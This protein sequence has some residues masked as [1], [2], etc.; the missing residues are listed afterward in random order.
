M[1]FGLFDGKRLIQQWRRPSDS[2]RKVPHNFRCDGVVVASVVPAL[3]QALRVEIKK[4]FG[5]RPHFVSGRNIKGI[6]VK[7]SKAEVGADRVVDALAAYRLYGGPCIIVDFGTAT[8][9]DVISA[10]GEYLGGAIAPGIMLGRDALYERTAKLPLVEIKVPRSVIG[11][12]TVTAIQSGLVFGYVAM[13]E[14]MI[15]RIKS[16][17]KNQ[18]SKMKVIATGGLAML[19]CKYAKGVDSVDPFLTLK[20]LQMIGEEI[21]GRRTK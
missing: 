10:A 20:G 13:V 6:R 2:F 15:Q 7:V 17:I 21:Y 11:T 5:I 14:G 9:F 16:K 18:K 12:D 3:D 8:T 19:I 1:V 4:R